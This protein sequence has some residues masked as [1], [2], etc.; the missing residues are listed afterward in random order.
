MPIT[1]VDKD[2]DALTMTVVADFRVPVR[3]LWDAYADP[4][5][6]EKF[7][8][9]PEWP[10]TF[11]RH[12]MTVGGRSA[13]FMTGPGGERSGGYWEFLAVD[14]P[15]SFEVRDGF[16][17]PDGSPNTE[18]PSMRMVY[19]FEQTAAGSRVTTTTYFP[20]LSALEQLIEMGMEEGMR[21]A[22]SQIDAVV[23]DLASFAAG[24]ATEAQILGDTLVRVSRVI[25]GTVQQVWDAHHDPA[26]LQRWLLGPDGWTM[27]VCEVATSVGGTYRY[28][29]ES[30]DGKERF[31][32][33]GELL[34]SEPPHRAVTTEQMIGVDGP[35]TVNEMTLTPVEGGTLL[36]FVITYPSAEV[37][38][39][40]L[41]TGMTDGMETSYARLE[42]EVLVVA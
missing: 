41:A 9:P 19:A 13:Y 37:R 6:I 25:R 30:E 4:R 18:M 36:S 31:G 23:T 29:W 22:M 38:D 5:Q 1:S 24:R 16:T 21:A 11:T 20:S 2:L 14:A 15:R 12:D 26:L 33:T 8:G 32:F 17:H 28:E 40:I 42:S 39:A 35:T 3:R 27:P 34:E 7:W 10:A